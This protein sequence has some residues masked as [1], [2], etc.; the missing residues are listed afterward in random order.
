MGKRCV[1]GFVVVQLVAVGR[2]DATG[3]RRGGMSWV[4]VRVFVALVCVWCVVLLV[5]CVCVGACVF[6]MGAYAV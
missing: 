6:G 5:W 2:I 3:T 1:L 4:G